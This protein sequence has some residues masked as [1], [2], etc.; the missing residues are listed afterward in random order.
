MAETLETTNESITVLDVYDFFRQGWKILFTCCVMGCGIG[1]GA[2]FLWPEKYEASA[3]IQPG[4]M[5]I[6]EP[7]GREARSGEIET[8]AVLAEKM[9]SPTYY[10]DKT[11]ES[12]KM[13]GYQNPARELVAM[14]SPKVPRQSTFVS[15]NF[16]AADTR[17]ATTCLEAVLSD[18]KS[19]QQEIAAVQTDL[20]RTRLAEDIKK[21]QAAED[22]L[23]NL[24]AK[25]TDTAAFVAALHLKRVEI[26]ELKKTIRESESALA[27]PQTRPAS[28]ATPIYA[29]AQRVEPKRS[30]V[31]LACT[32]AGLG[33]GFFWLLSLRAVRALKRQLVQR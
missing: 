9:R 17:A 27:F 3:L 28:F 4:R 25:S 10:S 15:V 16:R 26:T 21:L 31:V 5:P 12:C 30:L 20:V 11:L 22:F 18:V 8:P 6:D 2:A 1:I 23:S 13:M 24:G 14:L 29:P 19:N 32:V 33:L 7:G